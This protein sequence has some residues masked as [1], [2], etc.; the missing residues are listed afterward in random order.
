M[1]LVCVDDGRVERSIEDGPL[2]W[3]AAYI[4]ICLM[5]ELGV[6]MAQRLALRGHGERIDG[7][8]KACT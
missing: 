8:S 4:S 3:L 5:S 7:A 1:G 2:A 6:V